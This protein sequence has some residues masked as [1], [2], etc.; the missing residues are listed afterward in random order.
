MKK[1]FDEDQPF[2]QKKEAQNPGGIPCDIADQ[3][4]EAIKQETAIVGDVLSY[5][6][7]I[8]GCGECSTKSRELKKLN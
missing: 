4:R 7:H 1:R 8:R 2:G 5:G 3:I 6:E